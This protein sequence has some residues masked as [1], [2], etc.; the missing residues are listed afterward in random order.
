MR[1]RWT[2]EEACMVYYYNVVP[3]A[4]LRN[5]VVGKPQHGEIMVTKKAPDK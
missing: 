3:L 2:Y 5:G 1:P 4:L